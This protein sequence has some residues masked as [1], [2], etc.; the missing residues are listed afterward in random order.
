MKKNKDYK[1]IQIGF[2][3]KK[4]YEEYHAEAIMYH[5]F[6]NRLTDSAYARECF[7]SYKRINRASMKEK[8][9]ALV[10]GQTILTEMIRGA[11]DADRKSALLNISKEVTRL[12]VG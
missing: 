5:G 7:R 3:T 4:Q 6:D 10:E 8:A 12:W 9:K 1:I 2:K 11:E